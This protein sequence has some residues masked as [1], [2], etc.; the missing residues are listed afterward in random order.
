M[1]PKP[2]TSILLSMRKNERGGAGLWVFIGLVIVGG[3]V[4]YQVGSLYFDHSTIE[5]EVAAVGDQS[6]T[7]ARMNVKEEIKRVVGRYDIE[8]PDDGIRVEY[9]DQRTRV[10]I[11][12]AYHRKANF[13]VLRR[14]F[15]FRI[16]V[17]RENKKAVGVI[18]NIQENIE[19]ANNSSAQKY[20]NAIKDATGAPQ[21]E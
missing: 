16:E 14:T 5:N 7:S 1:T 15:P 20:R 21:S 2:R 3:W 13:L 4:A 11:G 9:N 18:Q 17:E 19:G 8:L 12:F 10:Q 6:L